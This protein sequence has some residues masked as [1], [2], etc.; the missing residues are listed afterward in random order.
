[1]LRVQIK[2]TCRWRTLTL[3]HEADEEGILQVE[4]GTAETVIC[5]GFLPWDA[6]STT[7]RNMSVNLSVMWPEFSNPFT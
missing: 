1:M 5:L 7:E 3:V 6:V 2:K 4:E